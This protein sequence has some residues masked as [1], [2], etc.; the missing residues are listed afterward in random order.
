LDVVWV[1]EGWRSLVEDCHERLIAA[2]PD[3]ELHAI[4]QKYGV[5]A[6]QAFPC[7][8]VGDTRQWSDEEAAELA[9][10][11]EEFR[12]RSEAVCEWCGASARRRGRRTIELTLCDDCDARISDPPWPLRR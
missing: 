10:I 8:R 12:T 3:Y 2:F 7:R 9:A 5:L 6:Y 4:K 11:T 1:G